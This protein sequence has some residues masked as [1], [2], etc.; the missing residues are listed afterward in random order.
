[1][2]EE[3]NVHELTMNVKKSLSFVLRFCY[4]PMTVHRRGIGVSSLGTCQVMVYSRATAPG[5]LVGWGG[6]THEHCASECR[7]ELPLW[8]SSRTEPAYRYI[9]GLSFDQ[10]TT[11]LRFCHKLHS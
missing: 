11:V 1:M 7:P 4:M 2:T 3:D 10:L 6:V 5:S 9:N 8:L